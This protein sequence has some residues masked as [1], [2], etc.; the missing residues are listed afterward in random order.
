MTI[1]RGKICHRPVY[2]SLLIRSKTILRFLNIHFKDAGKK[3]NTQETWQRKWP[4]CWSWQFCFCV[5]QKEHFLYESCEKLAIV[6]KCWHRT[7]LFL[8]LSGH[9]RSQE[10]GTVG[11][12]CGSRCISD[13]GKLTASEAEKEGLGEA[14]P[15]KSLTSTAESI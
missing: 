10:F 8:V 7:A 15:G 11:E 14:L 1:E 13:A 2:W 3:I 4:L 5:G 6:S 12:G 9:Q